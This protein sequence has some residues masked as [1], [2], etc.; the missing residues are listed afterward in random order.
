[1]YNRKNILEIFI[2]YVINLNENFFLFLGHDS[3]SCALHTG[4]M[5]VSVL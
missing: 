5:F 4:Q 3:G 1:M 2:K